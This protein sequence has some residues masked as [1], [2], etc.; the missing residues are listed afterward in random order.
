MIGNPGFEEGTEDPWGGPWEIAAELHPAEPPSWGFDGT[1]ALP[2]MSIVI[3][4]A[5]VATEMGHTGLGRW[6]LRRLLRPLKL[7]ITYRFQGEGWQ[8][9]IQQVEWR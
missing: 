4:S 9:A 3:D 8:T 2:G 5:A 7:S 1:Q 6:L